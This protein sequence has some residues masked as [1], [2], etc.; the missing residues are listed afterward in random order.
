MR[1][2]R[3]GIVLEQQQKLFMTT[4]LRQAI[5]ILQMSA[6][7][8]N[9]FIQKEME[10]NPFIEE[11]LTQPNQAG[12]DGNTQIN[13]DEVI[14]Y[15]DQSNYEQKARV[16]EPES[17]SFENYVIYQPSLYEYLREQLILETKD[18]IDGIIGDYLLGS[19]DQNGYLGVDPAEISRNLGLHFYRVERVLQMIQ[20]LQPPGIGARNLRECLLLQINKRKDSKSRLAKQIIQDYLQDLADKKFQKI[21]RALGVSVHQVQEGDDL[22]RTLNPKPG[23]Q[24]GN[25]ANLF[26]W[27]DVKVLSSQSGYAVLVNDLNFPCLKINQ[28]YL[29]LIKRAPPYV[30]EVKD[31]LNEKME[32]ALGLM[33]GI[34]QRR[35]NIYKVMNCIVELQQDFLDKGIEYLKPLTMSQIAELVD[36][37]ES[38]V[39]RVASNKYVQT[40]RGLFALKFFFN[41]GVESNSVAKVCSKS[42][43]HL[44][45]E[46]IKGEDPTQP[47][48]D[49]SIMEMLVEKGINISRRTVNKYRQSMNIAPNNRRRRF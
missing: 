19:L 46:M 29:E 14:E 45:R 2:I 34:E 49:Q 33:R 16:D 48:S 12:S 40:P 15:F 20:N 39:S 3:Q 43:K 44:I 35:L 47:L 32:A 18:E 5:S 41:S 13:I 26:I 36:I 24:Y 22:I 8:L 10:E 28:S 23:A 25:E 1:Q 7:E 27:P 11:D 30:E 6:I 9:D 4:E 17:N 38:T 37:H 21:A 42:V 31:Y